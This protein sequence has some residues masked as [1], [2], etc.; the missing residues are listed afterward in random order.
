MLDC[1]GSPTYQAL[2]GCFDSHDKCPADMPFD[3]DKGDILN[4]E[5]F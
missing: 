4:D 2:K 3:F 5:A 1:D